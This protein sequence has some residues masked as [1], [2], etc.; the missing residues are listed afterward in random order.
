MPSSTT[1]ALSARPAVSE[2]VP[3]PTQ[4]RAA[5]P[6]PA[7]ASAAATVELPMPIS[8]RIRTEAPGSTAAAP[9]RNASSVSVSVMAGPAVKSCVGVSRSS[10]TTDS[11]APETRQSWLIAAPP[12]SKFATIC[13]VTSCGKGFTPR[14]QMP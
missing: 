11:A 10:A 3:R 4:S 12:A 2:P 13:A 9:R 14:A 5:P 6:M 1:R 8:P 7:Q